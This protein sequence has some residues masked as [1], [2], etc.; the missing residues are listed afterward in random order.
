[1]GRLSNSSRVI[2][3]LKVL[4]EALGTN[5]VRVELTEQVRLDVTQE[6]GESLSMLLQLFGEGLFPQALGDGLIYLLLYGIHLPHVPHTQQSRAHK[7]HRQP[8]HPRCTL[9]IK[10][11]GG[12]AS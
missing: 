5:A 8:H 2:H 9:L 11:K 6:A 12:T 1:M 4:D 10:S 3:T 7:K